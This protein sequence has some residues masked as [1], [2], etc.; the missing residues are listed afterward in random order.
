MSADEIEALVFEQETRLIIASVAAKIKNNEGKP[1]PLFDS[2]Q[3]IAKVTFEEEKTEEQEKEEANN[4]TLTLAEQI[5]NN[6]LS[7]LRSSTSRSNDIIYNVNKASTGLERKQ[8]LRFKERLLLSI[9]N[10]AAQE[11]RY[12]LT[13]LIRPEITRVQEDLK[14]EEART[15]V[16]TTK[17][18]PSEEGVVL[19][20]NAQQPLDNVDSN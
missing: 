3:E 14:E 4:K 17:P 16:P 6:S 10:L 15:F 7:S 9:Y 11:G 8:Q 5:L 20:R 2:M 19:E 18:E 1:N 13:K 12:E